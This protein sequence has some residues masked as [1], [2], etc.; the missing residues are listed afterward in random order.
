[1][2]L[3]AG[4][5]KVNNIWEG[6]PALEMLLSV[7]WVKKESKVWVQLLKKG[8]NIWEALGPPYGTS[9]TRP[10]EE[11][12]LSE[13]VMEGGGRSWSISSGAGIGPKALYFDYFGLQFLWV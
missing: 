3:P 4:R 11:Q 13:V 6:K 12:Y 8:N 10:I 7:P 2:R 9:H 5:Q 1:M